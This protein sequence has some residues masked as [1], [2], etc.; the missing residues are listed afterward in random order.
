MFEIERGA[1]GRGVVTEFLRKRFN[2]M[3]VKA[4]LDQRVSDLRR[5]GPDADEV[6]GWCAFIETPFYKFKVRRTDVQIRVFFCRGPIDNG[7]EMTMLVPCREKDRELDPSEPEALSESH[8]RR[9]NLISG[10]AGRKVYE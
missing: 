10:D 3:R 4:A 8:A 1:G 2:D 6:A 7:A 9:K 5:H